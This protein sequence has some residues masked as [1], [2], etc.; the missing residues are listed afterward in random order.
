[1]A[2]GADETAIA[3]ELAKLPEEQAPEL[4]LVED[5]E[6]SSAVLFLALGTQ[7]R[8]AG[9]AGVLTGLDYAAIR[10]TAELIGVPL[11]PERFLDLR[12]MEAEAMKA[13]ADSA[14]ASERRP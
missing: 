10:P 5:D 7:W 11:T 9:M 3:A 2:A 8:T 6:G 12:T 4:E 13:A 14:R 1:M